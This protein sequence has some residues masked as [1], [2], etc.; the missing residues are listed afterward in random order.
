MSIFVKDKSKSP[1]GYTIANLSAGTRIKIRL[2]TLAYMKEEHRR[3]EVHEVIERAIELLWKK[4]ENGNYD[5]PQ[6]RIIHEILKAV[7]EAK[8]P[9]YVPKKKRGTK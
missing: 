3:V 9:Y 7:H 5:I 6:G 1:P 4:V 2:L 8:T